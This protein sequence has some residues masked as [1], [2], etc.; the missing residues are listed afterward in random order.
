MPVIQVTMSQGRTVEQ[1]RELVKVLTRETARILNTKE[2]A[3]RI[4]IYEVPKEN[5]GNAGVLG[6]DM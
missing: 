1:K 6:L 4:L 2:E 5:W 3:I